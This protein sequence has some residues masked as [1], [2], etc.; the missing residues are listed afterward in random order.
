MRR[1]G[2]AE[3]PPSAPSPLLDI[4][5]SM[6]RLYKE[7]FGRGPTKARA[8][9]SGPNTLTVLLENTLTVAERRLVAMGEHERVRTH[10]LFLQQSFED[11]KRAEVER[12]LSRRTIASISGI[13]PSHDVAAEVFTLAPAVELSKDAFVHVSPGSAPPMP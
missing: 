10:R 4:S 2:S 12:I 5:N 7:A 9:F 11:L 8:H 3:H 6:V 13:D 1:D